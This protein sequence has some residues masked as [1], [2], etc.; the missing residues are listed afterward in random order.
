MADKNYKLIFTLSDGTEESVQFIVPQGEKGEKGESGGYSKTVLWEND[1]PYS[2]FSSKTVELPLGDYN[3]V[4]I[5][6]KRHAITSPEYLG[7]TGELPVM[8]GYTTPT[9]MELYDNYPTTALVTTSGIAFTMASDGQYN[10]PIF[11]YGI[12]Y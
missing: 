1:R 7:T 4:E 9:T 5:F 3:A 6:Y 11:I 2:K 8:A 10:L 12:K